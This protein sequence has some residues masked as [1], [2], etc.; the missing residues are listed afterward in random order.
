M[1]IR[2]NCGDFPVLTRYFRKD[3]PPFRVCITWLINNKCNYR[4]SYCQNDFKEPDGFRVLEPEEWF[5]AWKRIYDNYGTVAVQVTGGEPTINPRFFE[6]LKEISKMHHIEI[7]TNLSWAPSELIRNIPPQ[8]V[9]R[10]GAS[11]HQ[12]FDDI[13][14][15]LK[16]MCELKDAG[17]K[18]EITYVAYPPFLKDG[19][20]YLGMANEAGIPFSVLS[21]QGEYQNKRYPENYSEDEIKFLK[22]LNLSIGNYAE[23]MAKWDVE[24]KVIVD[25]PEESEDILR[26][27][28]MGQMYAWV[29]PN[30]NAFRCC[31]SPVSLGNIIEGTFNLLEGPEICR[32]KNCICWRSMVVGEE[33]RWSN[34]WPGTKEKAQD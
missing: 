32:L 30:G 26:I 10:M 29:L 13:V 1:D 21:F 9:S 25:K 2:I 28:R 24:H 7:Q 14:I 22:R 5:L 4:C 20:K 18:V 11:F 33:E 6:V 23:A 15:F 3:V 16:K 8:R 34:R 17:Y 19:E 31:K 12:E 27:C